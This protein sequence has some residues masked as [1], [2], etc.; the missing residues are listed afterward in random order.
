MGDKGRVYAYMHQ[1]AS[2]K[3]RVGDDLCIIKIIQRQQQTH[4]KMVLHDKFVKSRAFTS[5]GSSSGL[6]GRES[7]ADSLDSW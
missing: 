4:T 1:Y 5:G 7:P 2:K 6:S 3:G